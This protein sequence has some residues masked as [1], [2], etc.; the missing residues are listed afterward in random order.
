ML[1]YTQTASRFGGKKLIA[2]TKT[3]LAE[4]RAQFDRGVPE[5]VELFTGARVTDA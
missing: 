2:V 5:V 1:V 3:A 4:L